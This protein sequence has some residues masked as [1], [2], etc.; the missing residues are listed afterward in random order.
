MKKEVL[1]AEEC[2]RQVHASVPLMSALYAR[3]RSLRRDY[4]PALS[5][6]MIS[7]AFPPA[8]VGWKRAFHRAD[9]FYDL[10]VSPW[11]EL[12]FPGLLRVIL[13]YQRNGHE[14]QA[15]CHATLKA[16]SAVIP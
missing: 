2:N 11:R 3:P 9:A 4:P 7:R 6:E 16:P 1:D 14:A 5:G 12:Q 13:F 8:D 15:S 10:A